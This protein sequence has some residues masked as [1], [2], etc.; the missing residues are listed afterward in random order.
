MMK[1]RLHNKNSS[2]ETSRKYI[3]ILADGMADE[4]LEQLGGKTPLEYAKTPNMDWMAHNGACG[5]LKTIPDDFEAGSDIANMSILGYSPRKYYTGRGPLE[6][7]SMGIDLD[8]HDVAYRCNLVTVENGKMAD[9]SAGHI[10]SMEGASLFN[11]LEKEMPDVMFKSG[12]SYRNLLVIKGGN[13]SVS[14]P[15]HDIVGENIADY[16][17]KGADAALLLKCIE[18]SREVFADHPVNVARRKG[19][20]SPATQIWPWSGGHKPAFPSFF[21]KYGKKG[22]MVSAVDLLNGIARCSG[23]EIIT[24]PGATGYLD[25]DY[26]AKGRYAIDAMQHLDFLYLHIE[27]PDEAGHLGSIEEKV[28]AIENVD[29]VIGM[30]LKVFDGIIAVLPDHPT[31]IRVKTHTRDPVPFVV[32]GKGKDSTEQFSEKTARTGKFGMKNAEDF[33]AFLFS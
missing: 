11:S 22:G 12:V 23:M 27:A 13:G 18:K 32:V 16:L 8:T 29:S 6:A 2:A 21:E 9:F 15:P 25:T 7:V 14:T 5:M 17:P 1:R 30:I 31:P 10:S 33:L 24:V 28:R 19:G 3:V 26:A 20:K 4:P